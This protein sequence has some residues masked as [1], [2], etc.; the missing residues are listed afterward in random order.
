MGLTASIL[1]CAH[2]RPPQVRERFY[3]DQYIVNFGSEADIHKPDPLPKDLRGWHTDNDWYR[4]FLDSARN[5]LTIIMCI[6]DVPEGGGGTWVCEDG[7]KGI[8]EFLYRHPE[9]IDPPMGYM[10]EHVPHCKKFAQ[11]VAKAGDVSQKLCHILLARQQARR[12]SRGRGVDLS[13]AVSRSSSRMACYR[14]RRASTTSTM[15]V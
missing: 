7:I 14:T 6:S 5:A 11:V 12:T 15:R 9:G 4:H 1:P 13:I 8:C 10:Y 2:Q 3:G